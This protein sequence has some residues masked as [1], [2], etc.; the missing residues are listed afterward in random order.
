ML[1]NGIRA[2]DSLHWLGTAA[3]MLS[4]LSGCV[5]GADRAPS[6]LNDDPFARRVFAC[7][8]GFGEQVAGLLVADY[9][10]EKAKGTVSAQ[11]ARQTSTAVLRLL[12]EEDRLEGYKTYTACIS[13]DIEKASSNS[14]LEDSET[15]L[16]RNA[17]QLCTGRLSKYE[18]RDGADIDKVKTI[19]DRYFILRDGILRDEYV[20]NAGKVPTVEDLRYQDLEAY[21]LYVD[22][23]TRYLERADSLREQI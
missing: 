12:P 1:E 20:A 9:E 16:I 23:I 8:S 4:V 15:K 17:I 21:E 22:C 14:S 18:G 5:T 6:F 10:K 3:L 2:T 13:K 11:A 19:V 7:A